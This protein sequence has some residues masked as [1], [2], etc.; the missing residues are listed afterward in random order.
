M[1]RS[2]LSAVSFLSILLCSLVT[3]QDALY[4]LIPLDSIG[5]LT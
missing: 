1:Y 3:A 5:H 2:L 4:T